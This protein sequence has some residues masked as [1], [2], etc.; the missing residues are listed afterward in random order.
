MAGSVCDRPN[1]DSV[2][3]AV[4][5]KWPEIGFSHNHMKN[6]SL[7][8]SGECLESWHTLCH[9]PKCP[10][11]SNQQLTVAPEFELWKTVVLEGR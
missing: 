4:F 3:T 6:N 5:G 2:K 9:S 8:M 1:T 7:Q 10:K 11:K